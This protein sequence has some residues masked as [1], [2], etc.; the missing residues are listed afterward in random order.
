MRTLF[1]RLIIWSSVFL[2]ST[3]TAFACSF[4]YKSL[5]KNNNSANSSS[6]NDENTSDKP[7]IRPQQALLN[8]IVSLKQAEI[9]GAIN[10]IADNQT[11][12]VGLDGLLALDTTALENTRFE[13]HADIDINSTEIDGEI[14]YYDGKIFVEYENSKV[15]LETT[16]LLDF[17]QMIPSYGLNLSLPEELTDIDINSIMS[18]L[19]AMEPEK[20]NDGYLF[21]LELTD[22]I[23]LLLKSDDEYNFTGVK[24]NKF[25]FENTYIYLDF[26]LIQHP[27]A[28]LTF[29]EPNILEYQNFSPA[30]DLVNAIYNTFTKANSTI[31]LSLDISYLD[32]PYLN[33]DGDLSYDTDLSAVSFDGGIKEVEHNR[34]HRFNLGYQENNLIVNYNNLKFKIE[35]QSISAILGYVLEKVDDNYLQEAFNKIDELLQNQDFQNIAN[36]LNLINNII[37]DIEI[38]DSL[39]VISLDLTALGLDADNITI[40]VDFSEKELNSIEVKGLNIN[41][42]KADIGLSLKQY[43]PINYNLNDYVSI[44]PALCLLEAYEGLSKE[45]RFRLEF[46]GTVDDQNETTSDINMKGGLQFDIANKYGYGELDLKDAND[47]NHNIKLDMR[48]FDEILF[49]YNEQTKGRFSSDFF[50]DVVDMASEILNN[51]DDHFYELF[52]DLM[53][54]M[55]SLPLMEAINS[56]DYGKLFEIG[57][58]NS[59]NVSEN[60]IDLQINGGLLGIDSTLNLELIFDSHAANSAEI[61]KSLR[62]YDF[63]FEQN[64]YSLE[65]NLK[66]FDDGLE[67]TRLDPSDTYI[68]FNSLAVLLRLGIN[69]SIYNHYHFSG[70]ASLN[71]LGINIDLPIDLKILNESG[72]VSIAIELEKIP[73]IPGVNSEVNGL[74]FNSN[75]KISIYYTDGYFYLHRQEKASPN[76]LAWNK[77]DYELTAKVESQY[78]LD[79]IIYYL[80]DFT[81]GLS[82]SILNQ[83][84]DSSDESNDN[85][86]I[87]Y[88]NILSD[89]SYNDQVERPYFHFGINMLELTKMDMFSDLGVN[90]YIN[91]EDNTLSGISLNLNLDIL[92][93]ISLNANLDIVDLG[94]EFTLDALL[95]FTS[96]HINDE[97]NT[98]IEVFH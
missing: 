72:D 93:Q 75:R 2:V 36:D 41:G 62:I 65:I 77:T 49:T 7:N 83:I 58:V 40:K 11:I 15:Y 61:I 51:K 66:Q 31:N 63:E 74:H 35:K 46:S 85:S 56:K 5:D 95:N 9:D 25:Y 89:F 60:S 37:K 28:D 87:H 33:F 13:G 80:C 20:I 91:P 50:T 69:T 76:I 78:F 57:L 67:E 19:D 73:L 53:N 79:N 39:I 44:D 45:N 82:D 86:I 71:V 88:E 81:L 17:I 18:K 30:F 54:S 27:E 12:N 1:K 32:R 43:T 22:T 94:Q 70:E 47:Y 3:G 26:N 24:T 64:I 59:L 68:D 29:T 98:T 34:A 14:N 16:S 4:D 55:S 84:G 97:L 90:V 42:Y 6:Q 48:S 92:V 10:I 8:S 52:G 21:R 23:D 96:A 38:S